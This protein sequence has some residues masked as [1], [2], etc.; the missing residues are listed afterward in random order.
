MPSAGASA[1]RAAKK[2]TV[3]SGRGEN[4]DLILIVTLYIDP[5]DVK[6]L[7]GDDLDGHYIVAEVKVEPKYGKDIT[8]DRDDFL[9]RTD[10]DG[11]KAKPFAASQIAGRE[12]LV[13]TQERRRKQTEAPAWR[14]GGIGMGGGRR[15]GQR[16]ATRHDQRHRAGS[17]DGQ[18]ESA[19]K[20]ARRTRSCRRRRPTSR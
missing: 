8:I 9:L 14:L 6:E 13:V 3:G 20:D 2:Q 4:E 12:A 15:T 17:R 16:R 1:G 5:A 10:K 18:G 7:I 11:E 19:G